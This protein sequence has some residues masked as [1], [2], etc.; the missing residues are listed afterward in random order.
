MWVILPLRW[1]KLAFFLL[2]IVSCG[3][4]EVA[5]N[6][7]GGPT[8]NVQAGAEST[9]RA[10][11]PRVEG[12]TTVMGGNPEEAQTPEQDGS[13][14]AQ[15][16][17]MI[18]HHGG[19][20]NIGQDS[21][22]AVDAADA[23]PSDAVKARYI[24]IETTAAPSW[25]AWAEIEVYAAPIEA[26]AQ[27]M[28]RARGASA[29][30]S[31]QDQAFPAARAVDGDLETS[32]S[33]GQLAPAWIQV[34]LGDTYIIQSVRLRTTQ[35][36]P[37]RTI[38]VIHLGENEAQLEPRHT[39]DQR[40]AS[41][42]WLLYNIAEEAARVEDEAEERGP[43]TWERVR[44]SFSDPSHDGNPFLV[45]F[46]GRF[47]HEESETALVVQGYYDGADTWR[48]DFMATKPGLWRW[49]T[50]AEDPD[51]DQKQGV[52]TVSESGAPGLL[53]AHSTEDQ[54]WGY[55][56]GTPMM[57]IGVLV[58]VMLDDASEAQFDSMVQFLAN[59]GVNLVHFRLS[60]NDR[61]FANV[62]ALNM[63]LGLWQ[64]LDARV[65][66]LANHGIGI[67]VMLYAQGTGRPS[68]DGRAEAEKLLIRTMVARLGAFPAVLF[69]TGVAIGEYRDAPWVNWYGAEVMA[70]DP[71]SHPV[72]SPQDGTPEALVMAEQNFKS[73]TINNST[74]AGLL[75]AF[76]SEDPLP[77][78]ND[79]HWSEDRSGMNG[80]TPADIRRGAW[81][82]LLA[83]G[84][85]LSVSNN[86]LYCPGGITTCDRYFPVTDLSTR[87]NAAP[88]LALLN[89]FIQNQLAPFFPRMKSAPELVD[90]TGGKY[91][92][93]DGG[94]NRILY[95]LVGT[96]DTWDEGDG[97]GVTLK[98]NEVP[99]TFSATWFDPRSGDETYAGAI[100]GGGEHRLIPPTRDDWL[101]LLER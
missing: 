11:G 25:V 54:K 90:S 9:S 74:M 17:Q 53:A 79:E 23:L 80:H 65:E 35:G 4:S 95:L 70:L 34:D 45:P 77:V 75:S 30:A 96:E 10:P 89:P 85:G 52:L 12:G 88:W 29:R 67:S 20:N 81:K 40:T 41:D 1:A 58:Q 94:R 63:D 16:G 14:P 97:E 18:G 87:L 48:I 76:S 55:S 6:A 59:H 86:N 26:P 27:F 83:G 101:L 28:E 8:G 92:L 82:S 64:R 72:S 56:D 31:H 37:G 66:R 73:M 91:A 5:S 61:A 68:F 99:A 2:S 24:R 62:D 49:E 46:S 19:T 71:Y 51:L 69:N 38:H 22:S 47:T 60:E 15:G 33:A 39:F 13:V 44:L 100:G 36:T 43:L 50:E 21:E 84:M 3:P 93:A 57:P 98:L 42:E 7:V 78:T 32:W